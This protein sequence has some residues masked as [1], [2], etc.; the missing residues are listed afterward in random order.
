MDFKKFSHY[1]SP[2]ITYC[3]KE[4]IEVH[5]TYGVLCSALFPVSYLLI[6]ITIF[7]LP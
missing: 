2:L 3:E 7:Q 1:F 4:S 6:P 5:D